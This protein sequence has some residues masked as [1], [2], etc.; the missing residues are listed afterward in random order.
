MHFKGLVLQDLFERQLLGATRSIDP[1]EIEA[2]AKHASD[3]FLQI[4]GR[5]ET[6]AKRKS[7]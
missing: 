1:K 6:S 3:A 2:A 7:R 4:Y 5:E